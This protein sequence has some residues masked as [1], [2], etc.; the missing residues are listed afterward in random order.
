M[1]VSNA[2]HIAVRVSQAIWFTMERRA[3]MFA[4]IIREIADRVA[5]PAFIRVR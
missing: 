5:I 3:K 2:N 4:T 1:S